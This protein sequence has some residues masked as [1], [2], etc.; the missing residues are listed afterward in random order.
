VEEPEV[1]SDHVEGIIFHP[2]GGAYT[3]EE[4]E[5]LTRVEVA[6]LRIR[7]L[8]AA[9]ILAS[10]LLAIT[11]QRPDYGD[12]LEVARALRV[13]IDWPALQ[14]RTAASPF[15]AAFFTLVQRLGIDPRS[16]P[17]EPRARF[18]VAL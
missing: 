17:A 5:Q 11:E 3:V 12:V 16:A 4:I 14:A 15:A 1:A 2:A 9:N 8:P 13:Q 18:T 6:A 10:K 7:V